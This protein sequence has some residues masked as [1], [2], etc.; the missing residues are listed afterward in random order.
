MVDLPAEFGSD[1]AMAVRGDEKA[2]QF[3]KGSTTSGVTQY[4]CNNG[5]YSGTSLVFDSNVSAFIETFPDGKKITYGKNLG[6]ANTRYGITKIEDLSG[7]KHTYTY[8]TAGEAN[9]IKS[10]E[11]PGGN[12]CTLHYITGSPTS[13]LNAIEDWGGR[14]WTMAYDANR[15]MTTLTTPMGCATKYGYTSDL[16]TRI[17]DP[18][19]F[20]S[21]YAYDANSRVASVAA[22][23]GVWTYAYGGPLTWSGSSRMDPS[24]AITTYIVGGAG[25]TEELHPEGYT[26]SYVYSSAGYRSKQIEPYGT[27][28]S[29]THDSMGRPLVT[30]DA[31]GNRSTQQY[32]TSGEFDD[33]DRR[34]R[35]HQ[36]VHV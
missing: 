28:Y 15:Q 13:L 26:T 12:R 36:L 23:T 20:A 10:I 5:M 30:F 9:L 18:R 6:G 14:R 34:A 3:T 7:N 25:V 2:Y 21:T 1:Q 17:E 32:D 16:L 35:Q 4:A 29:M 24:G 19:G 31:L 8:G 27:V 11:V 33:G 22:G